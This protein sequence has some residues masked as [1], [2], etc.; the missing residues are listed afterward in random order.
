MFMPQYHWLNDEIGRSFVDKDYQFDSFERDFDPWSL[1][2]SL[3]ALILHFKASK[4]VI[5]RSCYDQQS[6]ANNEENL[7]F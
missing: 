4:K 3:T 5:Y 7:V 2:L 6:E 1:K